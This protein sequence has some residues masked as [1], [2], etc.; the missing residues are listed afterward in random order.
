LVVGDVETVSV[1]ALLVLFC[2]FY[3]VYQGFHS[4]IVVAVRLHEINYVETVDSVLARVLDSEVV[5]LC[6]AVGSVVVFQIEVIL[7][8]SYFNGAP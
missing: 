6:V 5:P 2:A 8:V 3:A 7:G 1:P 4:L